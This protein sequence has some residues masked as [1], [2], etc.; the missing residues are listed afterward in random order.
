MVKRPHY[1]ILGVVILLTLVIWKLPSRTASQIKLA[2]SSTFLPLFGL[3]HSTH[4]LAKKGGNAVVPR[5]EL[6]KQ[7]EQLQTENQ[8]LRLGGAQWEEAAREN[9]RLRQALGWQQQMPW[10]VKLARVIGRDP[11]NWWRSIKIDVGTRDGVVVNAAV[12]TPNRAGSG[13]PKAN[14]V[15][16]VSEVT[17]AQSQVVLLGDPDCRVSVLIEGPAPEHGVIAPASSGALDPSI[18]DVGYLSRTA[19]SQLKAGQRVLTSG[20][21]NIFPSG[22]VVGQIVDFRSVDYGLYSA[23]RVKL[24]VDMDSVEEVWVKLP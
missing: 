21:G 7:I 19:P 2:I 13:Q 16:R 20:L 6:L 22:I 9:A 18:V 5:A 15:G 10:K 3:S 17:Y 4:D 14:L 11:A 23:A 1:I 24:A 12:L 8:E